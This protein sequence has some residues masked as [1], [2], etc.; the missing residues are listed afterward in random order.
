M[1]ISTSHQE[2]RFCGNAHDPLELCRAVRVSRRT[3][4]FALGTAALAAALP[5]NPL[6]KSTYAPWQAQPRA[7]F[8]ELGEAFLRGTVKFTT[9]TAVVGRK[10]GIQLVPGGRNALLIN[11]DKENG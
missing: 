4:C 10:Y 9:E 8:Y 7:D 2:C 3:F 6:A 5:G 1:R 11:I